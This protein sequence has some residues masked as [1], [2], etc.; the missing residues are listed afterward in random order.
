V[1]R[2]NLNLKQLGFS[3]ITTIAI[4]IARGILNE[5][6]K[7]VTPV[8]LYNAIKN[9]QD[10]WSTTP[11]DIK[12]AGRRFKEKFGPII[13]KY[14]DEINVDLVLRWLKE[15]RPEL[16]STI[17]NTEG[18]IEWISRQTEIIKQKIFEEL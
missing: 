1:K 14:K 2:I 7:E 16:Y 17:I 4:E 3:F 8:D 18:G 6:I 5:S 12:K 13:E 11:E 9:N 15:D 10:L